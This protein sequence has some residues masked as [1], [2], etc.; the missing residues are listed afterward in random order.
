MRY[1]LRIY[2]LFL[3]LLQRI[4]Q[5]S[6]MDSPS[7]ATQFA[8]GNRAQSVPRR[9]SALSQ[10]T[11]L[12]RLLMDD[13][14][15]PDTTPMARAAVARVIKEIEQQKRDMRMIPKV[16]AVEATKV[17]GNRRPPPTE[18]ESSN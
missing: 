9:Q 12:Q 8:V 3:E 5:S 1:R 13:A 10:L 17:P 11:E 15:K 6:P 16:K 18:I 7:Q 14:R 4:V 2:K